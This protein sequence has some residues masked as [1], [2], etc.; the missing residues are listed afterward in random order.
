LILP[1]AAI[2][3]FLAVEGRLRSLWTFWS[4]P[5]TAVLLLLDLGWYALAYDTGGNEFLKLQIAV[6]NL[7]RFFGQGH[8]STDNTSLN[9]LTWLANQTLPWNL[10]LIWSLIRQ[11][12]GERE[13][14]TGR[15]LHAWWISIFLFFLFAARS[16]AVYLLPM[17]PAI[18]LLAA[19]AIAGK[20]PSFA[21]RSPLESIEKAQSPWWRS[22]KIVKRVGIGI[23]IFDLTLM[24]LVK[25]TYWTNRKARNARLAF[26]ED[27][28]PIVATRK[29]FFSAPELQITDTI[30]IA[31]RLGREIVRKPL[32]CAVRDDYFL[33]RSGS[34][35]IPGVETQV[36]LRQKAME[37]PL[38]Q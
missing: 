38:S 15:F 6:E 21:E 10:V 8:F 17:Y 25:P 36:L 35:N 28:R 27:I 9:T 16:R 18:A 2:V 24:L 5:L 4:W 13:D 31:Y 12:R 33:L 37:S 19:R 22:G 20:I 29:Q 11:I 23:A 1:A 7:D 32:I 14:W 26:I 3:G 30:V 34:T